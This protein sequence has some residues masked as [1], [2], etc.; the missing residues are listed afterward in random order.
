V[1]NVVSG[2]FDS[3]SKISGS[4]YGVVKTAAGD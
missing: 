4:L 1:T 2:G 3:I